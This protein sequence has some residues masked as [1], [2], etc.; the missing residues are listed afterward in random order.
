M[1]EGRGRA[2][3]KIDRERERDRLMTHEDTMMTCLG[4]VLY[5]RTTSIRA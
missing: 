3:R 4:T 2:V 5:E 1:E